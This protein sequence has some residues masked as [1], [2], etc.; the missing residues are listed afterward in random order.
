VDPTAR[1]SSGPYS[2]PCRRMVLS[3]SASGVPGGI[4]RVIVRWALSGFVDK[5]PLKATT[6]KSRMI[7]T[8]F[9]ASKHRR[10]PIL[11]PLKT[12][13]SSI[14]ARNISPILEI[15]PT[16]QT[17]PTRP[18]F[19]FLNLGRTARCFGFATTSIFPVVR[20]K[21]SPCIAPVANLGCRW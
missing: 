10:A 3:A 4:H 16:I 8:L 5:H 7:F 2:K 1:P 19:R 12:M 6:E 9:I 11:Y 14:P 17:N 21:L 18:V 20:E 13:R 15:K